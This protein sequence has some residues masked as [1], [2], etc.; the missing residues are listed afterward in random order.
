[1]VDLPRLTP[2]QIHALAT[3]PLPGCEII[4][5]YHGANR[6]P[7]KVGPITLA[8]QLWCDRGLDRTAESSREG[9]PK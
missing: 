1:M 7:S 2:E 4:Q 9:P 3:A 6:G 8:E 5:S